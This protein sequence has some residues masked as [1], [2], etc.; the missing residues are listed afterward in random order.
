MIA[1][2][3]H[4]SF[5]L[6]AKMLGQ[7]AEVTISGRQVGRITEEIGQE[8]AE[9]RDLKTNQFQDKTLASAV[10]GVPRVAVVEMDGGRFLARGCGSGPGSHEASWKE[11]KIACLVTM[12]GDLFDRDPHPELPACFRDRKAV[13]KLVRG[14]AA[15]GALGDLVEEAAEEDQAAESAPA[16]A[17]DT[18]VDELEWPPRPL[19][20]TSVA[21]TQASEAF[22]PMVAAEARARNFDRAERKAFVADGGKWIWSIQKVYFPKYTAINDFIHVVSYVYLAAKAVG[23]SAE[24]HWDMYLGWATACWQG[25]VE[26]VIE[27]LTHWQKRLGPMPEGLELPKSDPRQVVSKSLTYLENNRT[28]MNYPEY[29]RQGLPTMS[30]LVESLI[31]QFNYRVK[32][33]EKS[34]LL[35]NAESILQVRAVLLSEDERLERHMDGRMCLPFRRY[36]RDTDEGKAA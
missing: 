22:G 31:K 10:I 21:T 5:G 27:E 30:G 7:L 18:A 15:Q 4:P 35:E 23:S 8:M 34:W 26:T 20:R 16:D 29:R 13:A 3:S 36:K 19:V 6:A 14:L 28:R 11:D 32:G 17:E 25:Q 33:T 1:G 2:G 24:A 9:K 12:G